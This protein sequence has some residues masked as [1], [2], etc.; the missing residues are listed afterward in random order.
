MGIFDWLFGG[1]KTTSPEKKEVIVKKTT[2]EISENN[3]VSEE[4]NKIDTKQVTNQKVKV[5]I[6]ISEGYE[7]TMIVTTTLKN[8]EDW[9]DSWGIDIN[10]FKCQ[11][12]GIDFENT[13]YMG[14]YIDLVI[15]L[16]CK[17]KFVSISKWIVESESS[18][19]T[20]YGES[21]YFDFYNCDFPDEIREKYNI[22]E[23]SQ[24]VYYIDGKPINNPEIFE[25]DEEIQEEVTND[26]YILHKYDELDFEEVIK[27]GEPN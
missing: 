11:D 27:N 12:D 6:A 22:T 25:N 13:E 17:E 10:N 21:L 5:K 2:N 20:I 7:E 23:S 24:N 4:E 1:K 18:T 26:G 3:K 14:S 16:K 8:F 9:A 15:D 19:G